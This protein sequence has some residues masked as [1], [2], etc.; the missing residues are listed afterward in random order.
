MKSEK[1]YE[2]YEKRTKSVKNFLKVDIKYGMDILLSE[3][4][5]LNLK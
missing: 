4:E 2:N 1:K 3:K 5:K